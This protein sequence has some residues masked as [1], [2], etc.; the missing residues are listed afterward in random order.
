MFGTTSVND[1]SSG[2]MGSLMGGEETNQELKK[3]NE[4]IEILISETKRTSGNI[5]SGIGA[6]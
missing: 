4:N 1:F 2:P 6:L 3:L 5:V